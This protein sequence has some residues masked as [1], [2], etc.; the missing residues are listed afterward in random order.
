MRNDVLRLKIRLEEIKIALL[1]ATEKAGRVRRRL[2]T[3]A[4]Q[5]AT[6]R[7]TCVCGAAHRIMDR[8]AAVAVAAAPSFAVSTEGDDA[9]TMPAEGGSSAIT[10]DDHQELQ[11]QQQQH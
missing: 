9:T 11:Q 5:L 2:R 4:R 8:R 6:F 1:D 10:D 7:A 3:R